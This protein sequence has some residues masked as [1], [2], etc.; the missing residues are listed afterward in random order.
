MASRG[1]GSVVWITGLPSSGKSLLA[2][3]VFERLS[4]ENVPSCVLDGDAVRAAMHPTPGYDE[5]G[6]VSFYTTLAQLAALLA[7]QGLVVLVPATANRRAFRDAARTAAPHFV[8]VFVD[9][10]LDVCRARD[11]KGLY[12]KAQAGDV[13]DMPGADAQYETPLAP[14][15]VAVGGEDA[16]ACERVVAAVKK[17]RGVAR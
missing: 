7:R 9:V 6:R 13:S 4:L 12:E 10:P 16:A 8:E 15:V 17:A 5:S 3:R 11:A 1:T 2:T 14:D